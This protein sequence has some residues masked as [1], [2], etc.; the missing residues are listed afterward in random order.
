MG[1]MMI[2][3]GDDG[4]T[5]DGG[6]CD[7][8]RVRC[9]GVCIDAIEPTLASIQTGVFN[10]SCA[11][12]AC[13]DASMPQPLESPLDLSSLSASQA[14]LIGVAS[15]QVP[16]LDRVE[17]GD[18]SASYLMNKILGDDDIIPLGFSQMPLGGMLCQPKI[19][20]IEQWIDG[21]APIQ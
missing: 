16:T 4:S 7:Q 20:V 11:A 18:S 9:D 14:G 1:M 5:G 17:P 8:G 19:D 10:V 13:H 6:E 2:G 21:G 15:V 3:C 12:S